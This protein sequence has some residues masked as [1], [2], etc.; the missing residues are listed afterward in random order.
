MEKKFGFI[1]YSYFYVNYYTSQMR[2][3]WYFITHLSIKN[4]SLEVLICLPSPLSLS[5][6]V[7]VV[8]TST[9]VIFSTINEYL[10]LYTGHVHK[11]Q[12]GLDE[13]DHTGR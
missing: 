1:P 2:I 4:N 12:R 5:H 9:L 13:R 8:P 7:A 3:N 6:V 10:Y 11:I